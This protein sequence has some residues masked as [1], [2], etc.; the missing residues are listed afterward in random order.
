[1]SYPD[2]INWSEHLEEI[3]AV[4]KMRA[5]KVLQLDKLK[6]PRGLL[7]L[8]KVYL[9]GN[10][11]HED[12]TYAQGWRDYFKEQ[13]KDLGLIC[14]S[15][16]DKIFINYE[17]EGKDLQVRLK[18][19]LVDG[20]FLS[21]CETMRHVRSRDLACA[22]IALFLVVVLNPKV[23]TF[24]TV[25]EIITSKRANR[26]V[27]LVI[28]DLGFRGIPLWLASYFRPE[29]VYKCLDD[30]IIQLR[31]I[32]AGEVELNSKYW[33]ILAPEFKQL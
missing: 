11:E 2:F 7:Y 9:A 24:G 18:Q 14:L 5:S 16:L 15:P 28:P 27:F 1:M 22:D 13:T 25:D 30:V 20:D 29:W 19:K 23:P 17:K 32:D 8:E 26:P 10:L 4:V 12:F 6:Q 3:G 33:R 21:V 31:K